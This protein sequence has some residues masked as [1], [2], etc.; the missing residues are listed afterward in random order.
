MT[1]DSEAAAIFDAQRQRLIR[2]AYRML[3][4]LA[5]AEDVVQ[6]AWLRWHQAD[7]ASVRD[8]AAFLARTV[9]RL[10]LDV[11]KS[12]RVRRE[13]YVGPWLPEPILVAEEEPE[14][15]VTLT[16][17]MALERLSPLERAAFLLHDV[18]GMA[19]EEVAVAIDRDA[20]ACRQL[21]ARA[22]AHVRGERPRFPVEKEKGL[23]I[24]SAFF[25]ASRSGDVSAL[26][27]LLAADVVV[28]S[29][30]GGKRVAAQKPVVGEAVA[31]RF[32]AHWAEKAGYRRPPVLHMGLIDGLPGYVTEEADGIQVTAFAIE[33]ERIA[34]IYVIRNPDKLERLAARFGRA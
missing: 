13:A 5:E 32:F 17:M 27:R 6:D 1:G 11:L 22:R 15:D 18:F 10:A 8:P 31:A 28:H 29:D 20:A 7:R 2:I 19:F 3:G 4:S 30:G 12:A 34:A 23:A 21:A 16:L 26:R 24:A 14:D 9:S 33:G 25:D